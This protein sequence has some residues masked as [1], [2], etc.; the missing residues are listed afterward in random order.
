MTEEIPSNTGEHMTNPLQE[1]IDICEKNLLKAEEELKA[2]APSE[3]FI[4]VT[5]GDYLVQ[6]RPDGKAG[7]FVILQDMGD[8]KRGL[9]TGQVP[10]RGYPWDASFMTRKDAETIAECHENFVVVKYQ[11]ALEERIEADKNML[12]T[13]KKD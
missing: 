5:D 2:V 10:V 1:Y 8:G 4:A 3:D 11:K 9:K 13:I 7:P 6:N 12:A